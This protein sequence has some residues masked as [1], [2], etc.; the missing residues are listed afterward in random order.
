MRWPARIS[1]RWLWAGGIVAGFL[2]LLAI[3]FGVVYPRIG[4]Y[5]IKSRFGRVASRIDRTIDVGSIDVSF[6]HATLRDISIRGP[7]D[8]DTPLVHIDQTDLEFDAW[9]SLFGKVRLGEA[10]IDGIVANLRR[11]STGHDN[12]RDAFEHLREKSPSGSSGTSAR[13]TKILV[14]HARL[15]ANDDQTG[16]TALVGDA[17]AMW[18]KELFVATGRSITAT[19]TAAPKA[20]LASVELRRPAGQPPTVTLE[21]GELSLWPRMALSGIGGRIVAS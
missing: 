11:D 2:V 13:P 16:T 4:A 15:I 5:M 21:G 18:T 19:T 1:K 10:K 8:G 3:G 20:M 7:N 9:G 6:G 12:V 14:T 17:S